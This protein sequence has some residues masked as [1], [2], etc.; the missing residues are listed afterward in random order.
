ML[1]IFIGYLKNRRQH[2]RSDNKKSKILNIT[3]GRPVLGPLIFCIFI[4]NPSDILIFSEPFIFSR[5]LKFLGVQRSYF[6]VQ[7]DLHEIEKWV[8]QIKME[9]A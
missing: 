6:E 9:L 8:I 4:N 1:E 5:D 7:D 3:S 2:V